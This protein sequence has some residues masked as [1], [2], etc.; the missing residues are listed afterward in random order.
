MFYKYLY[1]IPIIQKMSSSLFYCLKLRCDIDK[2][3]WK[4]F[5][6]ILKYRV[7]FSLRGGFFVAC[8]FFLDDTK[9]LAPV[10]N[11]LLSD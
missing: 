2:V 1:N 5:K 11:F 7:S 8:L 4:I 9:C 6:Y 3:I 10:A